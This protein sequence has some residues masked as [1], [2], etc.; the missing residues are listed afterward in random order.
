MISSNI[1]SWHPSAQRMD[2]SKNR[3]GRGHNMRKLLISGVLLSTAS[4]PAMAA[5]MPVKAPQP[6]APYSDWSSIYIGGAGGYAWG[7]EKIDHLPSSLG[8]LFG[9]STTSSLVGRPC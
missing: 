7:K 6:V 4:I 2:L 8:D 9:T 1:L 3:F 5:D